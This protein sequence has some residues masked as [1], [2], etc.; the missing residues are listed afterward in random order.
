MMGA[1]QGEHLGGVTS[2]LDHDPD[3]RGLSLAPGLH[4][5]KVGCRP[6]QLAL[7][8]RYTR[9]DRG[10]RRLAHATVHRD[11]AVAHELSR[12][13]T[14]LREAAAV[15]RVVESRLEADEERLAGRAGPLGRALERVLHLALEHAIH[16][17][18]P[19]LLAEL[20]RE[21]LD[22]AP[23]LLV[24]ARR[25]RAALERALREALLALQEELHAFPA[26]DPA[27]RPRV[28]GH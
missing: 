19:L 17:T 22:L 13:G 26:A 2:G 8:D 24:H 7:R 23:P 11:M 15:H 14:R 3:G 21:V 18:R 20:E 25:G 28:P 12:L 4:P 27:D 16:P 5:L 6:A 10:A 9:L 1:R